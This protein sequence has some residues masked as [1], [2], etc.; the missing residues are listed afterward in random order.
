MT[1]DTA[2]RERLQAALKEKGIPTMVYYPCPLHL[3]KVYAPLGYKRGDLPVCE[4]L[5]D[6]VL[7]LPMHGY[8]T[9]EEIDRVC[10]A[11]LEA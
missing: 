6:C 8:I 11:L 5:T 10:D 3:Q 9:D 7:S 2:E 1:K 4:Q